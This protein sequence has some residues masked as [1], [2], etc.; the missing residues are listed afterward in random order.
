M[1]GCMVLWSLG[2]VLLAAIA[3]GIKNWR[4]GMFYLIA[5]PYS[6]YILP[7]LFYMFESPMFYI[8]KSKDK[9][10]KLLNKIAKFN[11]KP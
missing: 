9:C 2:E 4:D 8:E 3:Y 1:I 5:L 6:L 7:N 10:R 11:K